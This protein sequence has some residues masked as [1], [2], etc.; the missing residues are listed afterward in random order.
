MTTLEEISERGFAV[1]ADVI[2]P[3]VITAVVD[4]LQKLLLVGSRRA[5][6]R[7]LFMSHL[8]VERSYTAKHCN[9]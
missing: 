3:E 2:S 6:L 1:I 7:N 8:L 4:E 9:R 5:G